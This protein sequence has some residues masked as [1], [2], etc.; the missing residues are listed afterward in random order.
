VVESIMDLVTSLRLRNAGLALAG[1]AILAACSGASEAARGVATLASPGPSA[2]DVEAT[3]SEPADGQQAFL[4][5]A[6]CMRDQGLDFPDPQFG[7]DGGLTIGGPGQGAS[8]IDFR[9][10]EFQAAQEACGEHLEGLA[11]DLD[12]EQ[13]AELQDSLVEF[14]GCMRD[15]GIDMPDPQ[16][17]TGGGPA[18]LI[19]GPDS[20]ADPQSPEFQAAMETCQPI[21]GEPRFGGPEG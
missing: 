5:Y 4:D 14:A 11:P 1:A 13:R 10:E 18:M 9:S 15:H 6:D 19:G 12:P 3:S 16:V 2:Q 17:G 7:P 21:L 8:L 20:D